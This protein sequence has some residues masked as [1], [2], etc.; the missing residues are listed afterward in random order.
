MGMAIDSY[1]A[2]PFISNYGGG[3]ML[4]LSTVHIK[5][6]YFCLISYILKV[7]SGGMY[8]KLCDK[9]RLQQLTPANLFFGRITSRVRQMISV[10]IIFVM[11][12]NFLLIAIVNPSMLNP[13]PQNLSVYYQNV[14]GLIPFSQLGNDHP[15][16]DRTKIFE[17]NSELCKRKPDIMLLNETWL[18]KS[19]RS[20]EVVESSVYN[21]FRSDRSQL[22]HPSDPD[23]PNKFKKR[24]GGVLIAIR[25]D[26]DAK[27]KRFSLKGGAE[28]VAVEMTI[29]GSKFIFLYVLQSWHS[30][31]CQP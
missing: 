31:Y 6:L 14:Q 30:W 10:A 1:W 29:E 16:L 23:N 11:A 24:G 13:G 20:N 27:I 8:A 25:S 15:S 26:I 7:W 5:L 22:T 12:I 18:N 3:D 17:L 28:I 2:Q 9:Y 4:L 19:I 21:V